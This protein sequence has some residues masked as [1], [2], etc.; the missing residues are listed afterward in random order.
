MEH[1]KLADVF[2]VIKNAEKVGK[3]TCNVKKSKLVGRVLEV[4]KNNDYIKNYNSIGRKF[5]VKLMNKINDCNSIKPRF[6]F[7]NDELEKWKK[8]YLPARGLGIIIVTTSEGILDHKKT[9]EKKLGG[10]LLG[11][12]Y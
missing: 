7:K 11:Y 9:E 5:E 6:S 8:R 3:R 2:S 4:M 12:V 1:D 10:K